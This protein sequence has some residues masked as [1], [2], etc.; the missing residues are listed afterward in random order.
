MMVVVGFDFRSPE[1]RDRDEA[2]AAEPVL[3]PLD[4]PPDALAQSMEARQAGL[5]QPQAIAGIVEHGLVRPRDPDVKLP[6]GSRVIVVTP[7]RS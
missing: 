7:Q 2:I 3:P 1:R 6:E 4:L 5:N